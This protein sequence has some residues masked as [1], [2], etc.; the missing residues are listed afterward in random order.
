M[1]VQVLGAAAGGGFPQWN[2]SCANCSRLRMGE[3]S[4][5]ARS[6]TQLAVSADSSDWFLI[7]ASPDLR[8]QIESFPALHP[9]SSPHSS[10]ARHTP[11]NGVVLTC[12]EADAAL[13]LLLLR[14]S[15][16]LNVYATAAVRN[17]LMED[18]SLFGVLRRQTDQVS[19]HEAI[20]GKPFSLDSIHGRPSGIS[21][22]PISTHGAF[23]GHVPPD[24]ANQ[25]PAAEAVIGLFIEHEGRQ[26]AFFPGVLAIAP[27]WLE[28]METCDAIFFDGTFWTNDE[29]IRIQGVG[30][31][32]RE[33]GHLPVGDAD[34]TLELFSRLTGPRKIFIHINNTN[35]MLDESS[36]E[37]RRVLEA[38]WELATDGMEMQL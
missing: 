20:P 5:T 21:C 17:L 6:Q 13:G 27:E 3:F 38:G 25:L 26:I 28:Q 22:T 24:R 2:C 29:L 30:K 7:N 23:P 8:Y 4:G 36:E 33:M 14:E 10:N 15:Q 35:P 18:N 12:A 31:T 37:H 11:I 9:N 1:L 19:W 16:P 34:G 32:A